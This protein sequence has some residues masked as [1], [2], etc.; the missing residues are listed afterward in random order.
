MRL[1]CGVLDKGE[2]ILC[3]EDCKPLEMTAENAAEIV[4]RWNYFETQATMKELMDRNSLLSDIA[5]S[6]IALK[7]NIE[8]GFQ[9]NL[10]ALKRDLLA[11]HRRF[12]EE[13]GRKN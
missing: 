2:H 3:T 11:F 7:L 12:G 8:H 6:A 13:D 1:M 10:Y 4:K 9:P 5:L